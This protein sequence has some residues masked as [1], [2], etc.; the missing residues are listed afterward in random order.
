MLGLGSG[1]SPRSRLRGSPAP[2]TTAMAAPPTPALP[3]SHLRSPCPPSSSSCSLRVSLALLPSRREGLS[4]RRGLRVYASSTYSTE[5]GAPRGHRAVCVGEL[6]VITTAY[7]A[8]LS[9]LWGCTRAELY[10]RARKP[11]SALD[12]PQQTK[13]GSMRAGPFTTGLGAARSLVPKMPS[14]S[15]PGCI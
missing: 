14:L 7:F 6:A 9:F 3:F 5:V 4:R 8:T 12:L 11:A 2:A 13:V 15:L 1:L 10:P